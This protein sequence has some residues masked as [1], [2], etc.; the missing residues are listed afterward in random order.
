MQ[1][2][3]AAER[4]SMSEVNTATTPTDHLNELLV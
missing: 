4:V 2:L 3:K 1:L